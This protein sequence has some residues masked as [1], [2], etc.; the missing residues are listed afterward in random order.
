LG[1]EAQAKKVF[2]AS[3]DG[4]LDLTAKNPDGSQLLL[5]DLSISKLVWEAVRRNLALT[6]VTAITGV[7]NAKARVTVVVEK[8]SLELAGREVIAEVRLSANIDRPGLPNSYQTR[9]YGK[10]S[11]TNLIGDQG[12]AAALSEALTIALNNLNFS[13]LD[14]FQ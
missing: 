13:G 10:A 12:G 9:G 4:R 7:T 6:G 1:P 5:S 3:S 8:M 11:R 14:N 2:A